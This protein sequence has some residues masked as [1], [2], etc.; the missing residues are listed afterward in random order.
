MD[1]QK[2]RDAREELGWSRGDLIANLDPD[3]RVL[4]IAKLANIELGNRDP[5]EDEETE[6][7]RVLRGQ[8]HQTLTESGEHSAITIEDDADGT[9]SVSI[10]LSQNGVEA[11]RYF[12]WKGLKQGDYCRVRGA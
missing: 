6:L 1:G 8:L 10:K 5:N 12:S 3:T 11:T 7:K 2:I 9:E 4:T